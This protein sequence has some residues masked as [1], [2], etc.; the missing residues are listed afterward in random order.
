VYRQV[1][2]LLAVPPGQ[3]GSA[4]D[5]AGNVEAAAACGWNAVRYGW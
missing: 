2:D 1:T 4:D 3:I 5:S